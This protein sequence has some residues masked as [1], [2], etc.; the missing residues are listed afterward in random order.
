[1]MAKAEPLPFYFSPTDA[2]R[3][4]SVSSKTVYLWIRSGVLPASH[5][6]RVIRVRKIDLDAMMKN[7]IYRVCPEED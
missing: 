5:I 1:M 7:H 4:V 3:Y 2:A 6:G